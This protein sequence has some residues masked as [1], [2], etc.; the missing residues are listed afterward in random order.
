MG[1]AGATEGG[2]FVQA[3]PGNHAAWMYQAIDLGTQESPYGFQR[4]VIIGYELAVKDEQGTPFTISK[5]CKPSFFKSAT[6]RRLV[7]G[8]LGRKLSSAEI[9]GFKWDECLSVPCLVNVSTQE[10][11][12]GTRSII[13]SVASV[14]SGMQVSERVAEPI[15]FDL[16]EPDQ[17]IFNQLSDGLKQI[18]AKSP[19]FALSGLV[20]E[21]E[22]APGD[23]DTEGLA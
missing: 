1:F 9:P 3:P 5:W 6:M 14:P 23:D 20:L 12:K 18:I 19:Q 22:S 15:I 13:A 17:V 16:N 7:E 11:E 10:T 21:A 2:V 8:H 4:K